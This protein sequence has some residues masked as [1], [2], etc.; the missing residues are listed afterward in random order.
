MDNENIQY[1]QHPARVVVGGKELRV[2]TVSV[3]AHGSLWLMDDVKMD[4]Y[5]VKAEG[6]AGKVFS[7]NCLLEAKHIYASVACVSSILFHPIGLESI[8][9]LVLSGDGKIGALHVTPDGVAIV[10]ETQLNVPLSHATL[11]H[12]ASD[13]GSTLR[14]VA[15]S[16][17]E[18]F[19]E[20]ISVCLEVSCDPVTKAVTPSV[21]EASGLYRVEGQIMAVHPFLHDRREFLLSISSHGLVDFWDMN[22]RCEAS[23]AF[24]ELE[25]D[26]SRYGTVTSSLLVQQELW[27][28]GSRGIIVVYPLLGEGR[29]PVELFPGKSGLVEFI[30]TRKEG[31]V[32]CCVNGSFVCVW[33]SDE[34]S[35]KHGLDVSRAEDAAIHRFTLVAPVWVA[36]PFS[37]T[38]FSVLETEEPLPSHQGKPQAE[39]EVPSFLS[40]L[41]RISGLSF[42]SLADVEGYFSGLQSLS[43]DFAHPSPTD[44][45]F[46]KPTEAELTKYR[47]E[48]GKLLSQVESLEKERADLEKE[49]GR[50]RQEV[51]SLDSRVELLQRSLDAAKKA[52][53][54]SAKEATTALQMEATI[55][56]CN[57]KRRKLDLELSV[58]KRQKEVWEASETNAQARLTR[59]KLREEMSAIVVRDFVNIQNTLVGQVKTLIH[60]A[61]R[62]SSNG[63]EWCMISKKEIEVLHTFI[64]NRIQ[65]Q[66]AFLDS[67]RDRMD[68]VVGTEVR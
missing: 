23:S 32:W 9:T 6:Y 15:C 42:L 22:R 5:F 68:S 3:D 8:L 34:K 28:G 62:N 49:L 44:K 48:N 21:V 31:D 38:V 51:R 64:E 14:F 33:E 1:T 36:G 24:H 16:S 30:P 55:F 27:I 60:R 19:T 56:E 52:A 4:V 2:S 17:F 46:D 10:Y 18:G 29:V 37:L 54:V 26:T 63:G 13:T 7:E 53:E 45:T 20:V 43:F 67:M 12:L 59:L 40:R 35:L 57:E 50:S 39:S 41:S 65:Q 25:W 66:R 58:L 47:V 11:L 61:S